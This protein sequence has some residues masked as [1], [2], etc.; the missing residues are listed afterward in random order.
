[1]PLT[2]GRRVGSF[3]EHRGAEAAP[4]TTH[5]RPERCIPDVALGALMGRGRVSVSGAGLPKG[6]SIG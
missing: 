5:Q 6:W 2:I 1:M 3:L 4:H